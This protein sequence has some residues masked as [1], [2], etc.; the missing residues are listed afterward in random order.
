M[1]KLHATSLH[2]KLVVYYCNSAEIVNDGTVELLFTLIYPRNGWFK[3][4]QLN[5]LFIFIF[6]IRNSRDSCHPK[7][8]W[9]NI[10]DQNIFI[11][12]HN[13]PKTFLF[14]KI[15]DNVG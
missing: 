3:H 1:N 8:Y 5:K 6:M 12:K 9:G 15:G 4:A 2:N 7:T 10:L 11:Q 14:S 13:G